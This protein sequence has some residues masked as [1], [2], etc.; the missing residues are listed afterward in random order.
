MNGIDI[1]GRR[2]ELAP[3]NIPKLHFDYHAF[4]E[5][6]IAARTVSPF[7]I[8]DSE[9]Y[10]VSESVSSDNEERMFYEATDEILVFEEASTATHVERSA[11]ELD[12]RE[13]CTETGSEV[14]KLIHEANYL[15]N[16]LSDIC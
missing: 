13:N 8:S 16:S 3:K 7:T 12:I 14:R 5:S 9:E 1:E 11:N 10:P 2:K 4:S 6:E 15:I